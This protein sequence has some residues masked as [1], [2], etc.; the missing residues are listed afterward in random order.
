V[1]LARIPAQPK[2]GLVNVL[3][4]IPAGSKNKYEF[5]FLLIFNILVIFNFL[6]W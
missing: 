1:D 2:S 5:E 3:V 4:E 6:D